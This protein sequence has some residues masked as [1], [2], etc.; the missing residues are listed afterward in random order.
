MTVSEPDFT[1]QEFYGVNGKIIYIILSIY[2]FVIIL[3]LVTRSDVAG[4]A[5]ALCWKSVE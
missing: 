5:V 2:I 3:S 1:K 4:Q